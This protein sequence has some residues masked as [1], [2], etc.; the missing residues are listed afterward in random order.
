MMR[1]CRAAVGG[2]RGDALTPPNA[3]NRTVHSG[4]R[5]RRHKLPTLHHTPCGRMRTR[6]RFQAYR[7]KK[8]EFFIIYIRWKQ[9]GRP[10]VSA[11]LKRGVEGRSTRMPECD[12]VSA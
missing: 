7:I 6:L 9:M 8:R 1:A 11:D 4:K 5:M 2:C 12:L 3:L 10:H